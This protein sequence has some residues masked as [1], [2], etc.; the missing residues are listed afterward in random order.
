MNHAPSKKKKKKENFNS[1]HRQSNVH[2]CNGLR[3]LVLL[4]QQHNPAVLSIIYL[5]NELVLIHISTVS[6]IRFC[7]FCGFYKGKSI[8]PD[9]ISLA[10][11]YSVLLLEECSMLKMCYNCGH[12]CPAIVF[13]F[14][15]I[16][17]FVIR[18]LFPPPQRAE[19]ICYHRNLG[20]LW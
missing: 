16:L 6:G 7:G 9:C 2:K 17:Q 13:T 18:Q 19:Q 8:Q 3:L 14:G 5:L 4:L 1:R 10:V 12:W 20:V 11:L 15:T